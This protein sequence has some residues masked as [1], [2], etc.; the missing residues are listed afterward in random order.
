MRPEVVQGH[1]SK[2]KVALPDGKTFAFYVTIGYVD[3]KP[4]EVFVNVKDSQFWEHLSFATVLLSRLLQSGTSA[5]VLAEEL[6]QIQSPMTS[7]FAE[8]GEW[9]PSIYAHIGAL[10]EKEPIQS[11]VL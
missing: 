9:M 4:F 8:N 11:P 10:L 3:G 5:Q 7:H 1:T 6:K 2:I